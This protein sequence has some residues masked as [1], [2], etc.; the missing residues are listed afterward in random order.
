MWIAIGAFIM[1]FGG[2]TSGYLV[3][4][5][6]GNWEQF[7]LPF[8]AYISTVIILI[9]SLTL[10][11]AVRSFK[12]GNMTLHRSMVFISFLLGVAFSVLQYFGFQTLSAQIKWH[13]NVAFQYL[14]VIAL[15]HAL[16]II[17]GLVTLLVLLLRTFNRKVQTDN[18]TGL[19]L[20]ATYWHF[21]DILW[22]YLFVFF[23]L[24]R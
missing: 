23:L 6:Q 11:V 24:N 5:S 1:M 9:S 14:V 4:R 18:A 17:G 16:H 7:N 12:S 22:L 2:L 10:I 21:V 15:V 20:A 8:E 13:D 19:E 3:R